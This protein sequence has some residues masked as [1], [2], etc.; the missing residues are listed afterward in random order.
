M[1]RHLFKLVVASFFL[2]ST[3]H[4]GL[5]QSL[6]EMLSTKAINQ[7]KTV[8]VLVAHG[9]KGAV[10][11][12]DG[13]YKIFDPNTKSVLATRTVGKTKFMEAMPDGIKWAEEFPGTFQLQLIPIKTSGVM[14]VNG[15]EYKGTLSIYNIEEKISIVNETTVEDYVAVL[16]SS[17]IS[18]PM[19]EETMNALAI[20]ARTHALYQAAH[21]RNHYWTVDGTIVGFKGYD[22][23][24]KEGPVTKAIVE[25]HNL[26]LTLGQ[27]EPA[28]FPAEWSNV[29][30]ATKEREPAVFSRITLSQADTL[31]KQGLS[32]PDI[33]TRA[34]PGA[35]LQSA[36]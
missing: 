8:K 11:G 16:L 24:K 10:I 28:H 33:L 19:E 6:S 26:S 31:A 30:G 12:V 34:F 22:V 2:A 25:T 14:T 35:R 13:K 7:P 20:A 5:L 21:P 32:A 18:G 29:V 4:A 23:V 9:I 3:G 1:K 15:V 17:Q 27:G 36:K